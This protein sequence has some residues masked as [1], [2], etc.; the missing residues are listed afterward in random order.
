MVIFKGI[1]KGVIIV[2]IFIVA[3]SSVWAET[4]EKRP[5]EQ[6]EYDGRIYRHESAFDEFGS[7][8]NSDIDGDGNNE[9]L[10]SFRADPGEVYIPMAFVFVYDGDKVLKIPLLDYPGK[11]ETA[12]ID[13]DGSQE[14]ILYS[15]GGAHYTELQIFKYKDGELIKLFE[16]GSACPVN[17]KMIGHMPTVK[18]GRAKWEKEG[19]CYASDDYHWQI[20]VWDGEQ[21]AYRDDLSTTAEISEKEEV[22]RYINRIMKE[23]NKLDQ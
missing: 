17:F 13:R 21:F 1:L 9:T 22:G 2:I 6:F 11:I 19:W 23:R 7:I 20:Y 15:H 16:N 8:V 14:L 3:F 5:P 4:V 10:I 12:D 18:V